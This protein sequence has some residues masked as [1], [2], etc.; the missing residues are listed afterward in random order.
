VHDNFICL[1][2]FRELTIRPVC[3]YKKCYERSEDY[4]N[5][6]QQSIHDDFSGALGDVP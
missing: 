5:E 2:T 1:S 3:P 6:A 4:A